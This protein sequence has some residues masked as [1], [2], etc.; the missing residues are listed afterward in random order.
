MVSQEN[1]NKL[2]EI[3]RRRSMVHIDFLKHILLLSS[4]IF[5]ILVALHKQGNPSGFLRYIFPMALSPIAA[6]ILFGSIALYG[7]VQVLK[8]SQKKWAEELRNSIRE[9]REPVLT[10]VPRGKIFVLFETVSYVS[11]IISVVLL[12]VYSFLV[13]G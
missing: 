10:S 7:E 8:V 1:L 9:N 12:V 11:L 4:M 13:A 5:G 6:G 2:E 3:A